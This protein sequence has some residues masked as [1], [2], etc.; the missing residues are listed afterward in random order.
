MRKVILACL[1]GFLLAEGAMLQAEGAGKPVVV[2]TTFD[3][4]GIS[5]DDV[6][7]VMNSFT[8][9]FTDLGVAR[10]VDR[11]SFD[12]IRGELSFQTSD[13]SD[14]KKVAEL[15]RALNATQV[16][17]GQLMKR[18]ANFFLTVKILDVNTTT[19]ISSHLDKVGS[20][21]DFF[22]KMP[23]F[24]KKLVAKM[25]DAK[26]FSSVSDGSGKTQTSAKMGVYKIGDIGPGGGIIF[27]VNKRGFTVY[28]GK[29]GE[30][31]C[32]YL[33]MSN[34][35]L[36][37][38]KWYPEEINISTQTGLGYGKANT[39][40]IVNSSGRLTEGNC[41]AYRCS[42]Y[43]TPSTKQGEWFLPSKDELKL[44]YK[45]QKER[46]LATCTDTYHWSSSYHSSKKVWVQRF[47]DGSW[48]DY[49]YNGSHYYDGKDRTYSVRAVRA[50]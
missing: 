12:K 18:G 40:K 1:F 39:Y 11:G 35:T 29:G 31:I 19:V 5:E 10:V 43:S 30:E 32:H 42:K 50:F 3:A 13:W 45:S 4:K 25:S 8:T 27:Y 14:S 33:E 24:C 48:F 34:G 38:S 22:E 23:E 20:I 15:G 9:A 44:M 7:F 46:V 16:V 37:E 41:A 28:D 2:I 49:Y 36:G 17:I 21:D 47:G 6:E 26:A